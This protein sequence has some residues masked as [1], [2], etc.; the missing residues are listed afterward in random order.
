MALLTIPRY[1]KTDALVWLLHQIPPAVRATTQLQAGL[2]LSPKH[3]PFN[4]MRK[5]GQFIGDC[6]LFHA[7]GE[8]RLGY[9]V[10][11]DYHNKGIC[12]AAVKQ[13]IAWGRDNIGFKQLTAHAEEANGPSQAVLK[14]LGFRKEDVESQ[15]WPE[16]HGGG[17]RDVGI[18]R[19]DL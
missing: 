12:T 15:E 13:L 17:H 9:T 11:P 3:C 1:E 16:Y 2:P 7:E 10:H 8:W 6:D 4:V 18:W 19:L 5:D 14:K